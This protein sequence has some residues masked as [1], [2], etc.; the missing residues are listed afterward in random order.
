[1]DTPIN[2]M[3][4]RASSR[5]VA[6]RK[7]R[8]AST[9][10]LREQVLAMVQAA[11]AA[12]SDERK[13]T[14]RA[15]LTVMQ[16]ALN[17]LSVLPAA[18]RDFGVRREVTKFLSVATSTVVA[19]A[20]PTK[21]NDLLPAGHPQ[22]SK[23]GELT[24]P[25]FC[26]A[27]GAWLAADTSLSEEI[28]PLVASAHGALPD[29][30]EREHAFMRLNAT[31]VHLPLYF[32]TDNPAALTAAFTG[33]N[34]SAARRARVALQ[35]RDRMGR[36]VEMG[37]GINFRFRLP[38]GSIQVGRGRYVGA[39]DAGTLTRTANGTSLD[40]E[41]GLVEVS[42]VPGLNP[43]I[44]RVD[45]NNAV[46]YKA[47]IPGR[48]APA[49]PTFKDQFDHDIPNIADLQ[50]EK[51]EAP[52][53][54]TPARNGASWVSDDGYEVIVGRNGQPSF[55]RRTVWESPEA[56]RN[57]Q[58]NPVR[59]WAE[60]NAFIEKDQPE[61]DKK[62]ARIDAAKS[63]GQL[64]LG[65]VPED[66][67]DAL[68]P[69]ELQDM[70]RT[71]TEENKKFDAAKGKPEKLAADKDL[72][73]NPV[74][75]N[76]TRDASDPTDTKYVY[77]APQ[78]DGGTYPIIARQMDDGKYIAGTAGGW[79]PA[80]GTEGRGPSRYFDSL[81][82]VNKNGIPGLIEYL[83]R[84]VIPNNPI[85]AEPEAPTTYGK[86]KPKNP[87]DIKPGDQV[88]HKGEWKTVKSVDGK[89][90]NKRLDFEDGTY[91]V[92]G[93]RVEPQVKSPEAPRETQ[94]FGE[95]VDN[96]GK[97]QREERAMKEAF[98]RAINGEPSSP[99]PS[100]SKPGKAGQYTVD[101]YTE[102]STLKDLGL[103]PSK[104][105]SDEEIANAWIKFHGLEDGV[106]FVKSDNPSTFSPEYTFEIAE[107]SKDKFAKAYGGPAGADTWAKL[108][109]EIDIE[110]TSTSQDKTLEGG[111]KPEEVDPGFATPFPFDYDE[112]KNVALNTSNSGQKRYGA[113]LD[114]AEGENFSDYLDRVDMDPAAF[115]PSIPAD[116][117][118]VMAVENGDGLILRYPDGKYYS[119]EPGSRDASTGLVPATNVDEFNGE[120]N[121]ETF[122]DIFDPEGA[123]FAHGGFIDQERQDAFDEALAEDEDG[124]APSGPSGVYG[125]DFTDAVI[126]GA[127]SRYFMDR[128]LASMIEDDEDPEDA[129]VAFADQMWDAAD[130]RF[131]LQDMFDTE[132]DSFLQKD[133]FIAAAMEKFR[134]N[135]NVTYKSAIDNLDE[136]LG[137]DAYNTNFLKQTFLDAAE[138]RYRERLDTLFENDEDGGPDEPPTP[139]PSAPTPTSQLDAAKADPE[140]TSANDE[141]T[142]FNY[143][144]AGRIVWSNDSKAWMV[145]NGARD[146]NLG[147]AATIEDAKR[148]L[149]ESIDEPPT[150]PSGPS[151]GTPP[152]TPTPFVPE[153]PALFE[154]FD[155]PSG[156]F[157]LRTVSYEP[158]GRIDEES[159]DFTDDP[160]RLATRFT[161]QDL[162]QAMSQALLGNSN[163]NSIE[164]ILNAN[165]DDNNDILDP[166]DLP[167][168]PNTSSV[169]VGSPSGAGQLEFNAGAEY[170]PAEALYNALYEAGLDPNRVIASIYDA[171]NGNNN[172][173]NKLIEA[174]G[175][176]PSPEETKLVDDMIAEIRQIKDAAPE[177]DS[178]SFKKNV[179]DEEP[180]PGSL[181][182]NIPQNFDNPDYYIV[183][184]NAYIPSQPD[185]DENGY[186]DNPE[187]LARYFETADLTDQFLAGITDGSG[188]SLFNFS[189]NADEK[190]GTH[191]VPVEAIRDALQLQGIN[192]NAI[193]I[194]L[195]KESND[196]TEEKPVGKQ[197]LTR[198]DIRWDAQKGLYTD[199]NGNVLDGDT[200]DA[201]GL[202]SSLRDAPAP[203]IQVLP[204][205]LDAAYPTPEATPTPEPTPTAEVPAEPAA[206]EAPA[207]PYPGPREPGYSVNNTTRDYRGNVI[208]AG[209]KIKTFRDGKTGTVVS[210][211]NDPEYVRVKL[212]NGKTVVRSANQIYAVD[213]S[214]ATATIPTPPARPTRDE[215]RPVTDVKERLT[216]PRPQPTIAR[217][218][219]TPGVNDRSSVVPDEYKDL[220]VDS[221][222][223]QM[224]FSE[225][226]VR[227][228]EIAKAARE[229][230]DINAIHDAVYKYLEVEADPTATSTEKRKAYS[231]AQ[232]MIRDAFGQRAGVSFGAEFFTL[233]LR[234][235]SIYSRGGGNPTVAEIQNRSRGYQLAV[236][237]TILDK[238]GRDVG[239]VE[240]S[241]TVTPNQDANGNVTLDAVPENMILRVSSTN[242]KLG[243]ASA[244]N[245]YMENWYIAN[246]VKQVKVHAYSNGSAEWQGGFVWALNGFGWNPQEMGYASSAFDAVVRAAE[247]DEEIAIAKKL[248]DRF[249]AS[250]DSATQ[251]YDLSKAPTPMELALAGW[252][253][254]AKTWAGRKGLL[255]A[256]WYGVKNLTPDAIEQKQALGYRALRAGEVRAKAGQNKPNPS[257]MFLAYLTSDEIQS[258]P[259]AVETLGVHMEAVRDAL[260]NN[261]SLAGLSPDAK[262]ALSNYVTAN[263]YDRNSK[264]P[265][266][267]LSRI[268][269]ALISEYRADYAAPDALKTA[270]D[271]LTQYD[272]ASFRDAA[273][274]N[275]NSKLEEAGYSVKRIGGEEEGVNPVFVVTHN[276]SG[277]IFYVK[278]EQT[279]DGLAL[280]GR[281]I[282][283]ET[284]S[285]FLLNA[286]G[287]VGTYQSRGSAVD[288]DLI[289]MS[290]AGVQLP[291]VGRPIQ[292]DTAKHTG[293]KMNDGTVAKMNSASWFA[294]N[295]K[296]PEDVMRMFI[297]DVIGDGFDR[298]GGN[299]LVGVDG[300]DNRLVVFPVDNSSNN[301]EVDDAAAKSTMADYVNSYLHDVEGGR[302][303]YVY[304]K[305]MQMINTK[306]GNDRAY[307]VFKN[308]VNNAIQNID[309]ELFAPQGEELAAIIEK[310][311]TYDAFKDAIRARLG[312]MIDPSSSVGEA[313]QL[314]FQRT[315]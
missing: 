215:M 43:G 220:V 94:R 253:P 258:D 146:M 158:E 238:D 47:R 23:N 154:N 230:L 308:E 99:T 151:G 275:G 252:Y 201:A 264:V 256:H 123:F 136:D 234:S 210:I 62:V 235:V 126:E 315:A 205:N 169:D 239:T 189:D 274:G 91:K 44:Y 36:W 115:D 84:D 208:G 175:G 273:R 305:F 92:V 185:V 195:N 302:G 14:P 222:A 311:G 233:D 13:V 108:D 284:E 148:M 118:V 300:T 3:L 285:A 213:S 34:S 93:I 21:H 157:Q 58:D 28:R 178:V 101:F 310:W 138:K 259:I 142:A 276:D 278:N 63:E 283:P 200:V 314:V 241:L 304:T 19:S 250:Y 218:G 72:S 242:K 271:A 289:I 246:G 206:P 39:G 295:V 306:M 216:S 73:G 261:R 291:L 257:Q 45:K 109:A 53:G 102:E 113:L 89:G 69:Q 170:V 41:T 112:A 141:G 211:Q 192:T 74:P 103:D 288:P 26:L 137:R 172:N 7:D 6:S 65:R 127:E 31:N 122:K 237:G 174:Q 46:T 120:I 159:T 124:I 132:K 182:D 186:T 312:A 268:R 279:R 97:R 190:D 221:E 240:R 42:G 197:G 164:E 160:A 156:A 194:D 161:P 32:K 262:S 307:A 105:Y 232:A 203:D 270:G 22:S 82:D 293:I 87:A 290:P 11:N 248:R 4:N 83:N 135:L 298:H 2:E 207:L 277:Q 244:Y 116:A 162:I 266:E 78:Q 150:P 77:N 98:D 131:D 303:E 37:R 79:I 80:P 143:R 193:L 282:V 61:Y 217:D 167:D 198:E 66:A 176:V 269:A 236:R 267:D 140:L 281:G 119:V 15:A 144:G 33:G 70:L 30:P 57:A 121:D 184:S 263:M 227:D 107:G 149:D 106:K 56:S 60:V 260:K 50:K 114:D 117:E 173:L 17:D 171:A 111:D 255:R 181:I 223:I 10:S 125:A 24:F 75:A 51:V 52:L 67:A 49:A 224:D 95:G 297:S 251:T 55:V 196:M 287:V 25:D 9:L 1:M 177:E 166:A 187:L 134:K 299:W 54:W 265:V 104:D 133:D 145:R 180:L 247:S 249:K 48:N 90:L 163:D 129:G 76:W 204:P 38:D 130:E 35:W 81:D 139:T 128:E 5:K 59:D 292:A 12:V 229:R 294:D 85:V 243:F 225:W 191:E 212:D 219:R 214:T 155:A 168:T 179:V 188:V 20:K 245:R 226:G 147:R 286:L 254:G 8:N 280:D 309:N 301:L 86:S 29:S 100:E 16:R 110:S 96:I 228:A 199:V 68:D 202:D 71:R 296:N 64:P 272:Y 88:Y 183:D 153:S 209:S 231:D 165:V 313:I 40:A 18:S 152:K 27:Y